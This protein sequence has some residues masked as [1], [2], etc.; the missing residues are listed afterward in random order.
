VL[1]VKKMEETV[2]NG[3][4]HKKLFLIFNHEITENQAMNA[5]KDLGITDIIDMPNNLKHIWNQIP[6]KEKHIARYLEPIKKWVMAHAGK[7]DFILVQGDFGATYLMVEFALKHGLIP[8]YSTTVR[9]AAEF[10]K[11]DGSL[12]TEHIFKHQLFRKY[13][14]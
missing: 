13:G 5:E 4:I 10:T 9:Q 14:F 8:V 11:P 1:Q 2:T 7:D 6:A 3:N 12:K